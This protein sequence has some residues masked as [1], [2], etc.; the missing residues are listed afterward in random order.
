MRRLIQ[1]YGRLI[2]AFIAVTVFLV[3][4]NILLGDKADWSLKNSYENN[5]VDSTVLHNDS[6]DIAKDTIKNSS[7]P[8]FEV[9]RQA[10]A[11][12]ITTNAFTLEEA[13]SGVNLKY[14]GTT[15]N[16]NQVT[17]LVYDYKVATEKDAGDVNGH[18]VYEM[19][20]ATD[21]YG[22][23]IYESDGKTRVQ[24]QQPKILESN[25]V[26][27]T[28]SNYVDTSMPSCKLK[29]V[30]RANVGTYKAETELTFIKNKESTNKNTSGLN[31]II[32][33]YN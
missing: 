12:E 1:E 7:V 27:L 30:Y 20:D 22:H 11:R 32:F 18:V 23:Y 15:L 14:N 28:T 9:D 29:V 33:N 4:L 13:L 31:K 10:G 16:N 3:L 19:V 26:E 21:K 24:V 17:V 6:Y 8:Y 5:K 2:I 25:G